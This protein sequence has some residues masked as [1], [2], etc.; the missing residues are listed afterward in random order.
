M[1]TLNSGN[2]VKFRGACARLLIG[3]L[4]LLC[5]SPAAFAQTTSGLTGTI[6]D[7]S[8]ASMPG[9]T[10]TLTGTETGVKRETTSNEAGTYEFTALQPGGYQLTFQRQ[11]FAQVTSAAMR[12]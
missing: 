5:L 10:I 12:L 4:W 1:P 7:L 6:T 8:G 9:A 11:G 2:I 3:A